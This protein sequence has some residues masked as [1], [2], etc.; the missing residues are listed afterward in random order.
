MLASLVVTTLPVV[1]W[2]LLGGEDF[3]LW[4][5]N[6]LQEWLPERCGCLDEE[7]LGCR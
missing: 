7:S 4:W 3:S 2:L 6:E 1:F 5:D